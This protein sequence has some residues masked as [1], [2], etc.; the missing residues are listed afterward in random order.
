M[1]SVKPISVMKNSVGSLLRPVSAAADPEPTL[2]FV[3]ERGF[4]KQSG[5]GINNGD[6]QDHAKNRKLANEGTDR[7]KNMSP[8]R[9][10][11]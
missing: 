10:T 9:S 11:S 8:I 1:P 4:R 2:L 7:V 6:A 3:T 5:W